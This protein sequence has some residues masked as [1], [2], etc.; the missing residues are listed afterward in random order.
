VLRAEDC[1]C[2]Q[3]KYLLRTTKYLNGFADYLNRK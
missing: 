2:Q 3:G 1:A